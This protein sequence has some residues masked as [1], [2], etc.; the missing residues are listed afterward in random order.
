MADLLPECLIKKILCLISFK[1]ATTMS[2]LSKSWLQAWSTLPNLEF[3]VNCW[4]GWEAH[5]NIVDTITERYGKGKIPIEKFE[6]SVFFADSTK[7]FP[8]IDKWLLVALRNGVKELILHFTSYENM[9]Q[10]LFY[11]CPF[12]VSFLL[13]YCSGLTMKHIKIKS[14]SLKVLKIHQYCGIWEIEAPDLVS[15]DYTGNEIP[16][17]SKIILHCI[18]SLNTAWFCKLRKF[19]SNSSS[20]SEVSL[21]LF[22]CHEINTTDLLMDHVGSTGGVN[23]LSLNILWM[24]QII[25]CPTYV[26]AFLWSC[27]PGRLNLHP[28]YTETVTCF[29][30]R[31]MYMKNLSHSTSHASTSWNT[32]QHYYSSIELEHGIFLCFPSS[33]MLIGT[34]EDVFISLLYITSQLRV[35]IPVLYQ[36]EVL[37]TFLSIPC[38]VYGK[39]IPLPTRVLTSYFPLLEYT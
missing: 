29:M 26:D 30:D 37:C 33:E 19:L 27:H 22:K 24:N 4:Q 5:I 31:L 23:V 10:T 21:S 35:Y 20:W 2:I 36:K 1:K 8:L 16:K 9:L 32:I 13:E 39:T 15:L 11:S 17:N 12:I 14:D 18:S 34:F 38:G 25:E 28:F 7:L 6:L 3:F